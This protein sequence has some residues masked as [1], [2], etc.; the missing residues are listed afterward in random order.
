VEGNVP[1]TTVERKEGGR[2]MARLLGLALVALALAV[3]GCGGDDDE[4]EE[5]SPPPPPAATGGTT[6]ENPADAGG[7]LAFEKDELTAPAGEVTLV[8]ENPSSLE[9]NIAVKDGD[10]DEKGPVVGEG[11]TSEVTVTLEAGEYTFYCSVPGH[12]AGGMEGTL[13]VTGG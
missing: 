13:T 1:E 6:L 9:H 2:R 4:D 5:A 7:E 12:E 3:A 8:M 10:I 11:E